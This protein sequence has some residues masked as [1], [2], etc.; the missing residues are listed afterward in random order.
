MNPPLLSAHSLARLRPSGFTLL[1]TGIAVLG[2]ALVLA[3]E[4]TYGVSIGWDSVEY[5]SVARSLLAGDGFTRFFGGVYKAYPPLYP[6]LLAAGS[7]FLFDPRDVAGPLNAVIFGLTI[8]VAGRYLRLRLQS[9][10]LV[11]WACLV[12]ALAIP[13]T[14]IAAQALSETA[15]ILLAILAL[16]QADAFL[17]NG[18]RSALLWAA[19]FTALACLT[20][21]M[22]VTVLAAI[23]L[24]LLCQRGVALPD[25][26]KRIAVY[27]LIAV[28]PVGLWILRTFLLTGTPSGNRGR[29]FYS[30]PEILDG[31]LDVV[32]KQGSLDLQ[33]GDAAFIP[34]VGLAGLAALALAAAVGCAFVCARR[35]GDSWTNRRSFYVFGGFGLVYLI[36]LAVA[37]ML[38]NTWSGVQS[39]FLTP[40]YIPLLFAAL[41]LID[42]S[43]SYVRDRGQSATDSRLSATERMHE[44]GQKWPIL[45]AVSIILPLSLIIVHQSVLQA[46]AITQANAGDG[47]RYTSK[48]W[49]DSETLQ[50]IRESALT[51]IIF[52]ND[53]AATYIHTDLPAKHRSWSCTKGKLQSQLPAAGVEDGIDVHV[54]WFYN[55]CG[56]S[57]SLTPADLRMAPGMEPV[58]KLSDGA[59]FKVN[60]NY[61]PAGPLRAEYAAIASGEP[62]IRSDFAIYLDGRTMHYTKESCREQDTTAMFFLHV[63]PSDANDLPAHRKQYGFDHHDFSFNQYGLMFDGKCWAERVLPQYD[64]AAIRTGQYVVVA[65][66]FNNLWQAE[67]P[68]TPG[69]A[70][71]PQ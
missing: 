13:L 17:S 38:G 12:I 42:Q 32:V 58:A 8:L 4:V 47:L 20:R 68:F 71:T 70:V 24:L 16:I 26:A 39:R 59:I 5:I 67:F 43:W 48:R 25:K 2:A 28:T 18:K 22:G 60:R 15:F 44:R 19:A 66:D 63:I 54:V 6:V 65:G 9:R 51:G 27:A 33:F 7:L 31:M 69:Q 49:T 36:L 45:L 57:N 56:E 10:F 29:E 46:G 50:Y 37:M 62:V 21:F 41:F 23:V 3:R 1:L 35:Q 30:V 52:S 61:D 34:V 55:R 14:D 11:G 40:V 64:I 53:A